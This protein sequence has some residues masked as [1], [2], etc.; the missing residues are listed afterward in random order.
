MTDRRT[1]RSEKAKD[2]A[3]DA[4]HE[5][6]LRRPFA[7]ATLSRARDL[8]AQYTVRFSPCPEGGLEGTSIELPYAMGQGNTITECYAELLEGMVVILA[9]MIENGDALPTPVN[10]GRRNV[11]LNIRLTADERTRLEQAA[12]RE[13]FSTVAEFVRT[14]ALSRSA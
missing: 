12:K 5:K 13:G 7:K 14:M 6:W 10:S 2:S 8:A 9:T 3:R 1:K 4:E 11:Q